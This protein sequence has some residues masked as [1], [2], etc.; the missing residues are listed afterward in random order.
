MGLR[1]KLGLLVV[2]YVASVM[3]LVGFL[4]IRAERQIFA[5]EMENR[6]ATLL[7]SLAIP[8]SVA[9]ADRDTPALDTYVEQFA[10]AAQ[11]VDLVYMAV[12]DHEGRVVAHTSSEEF[13]KMY[14][15]DFTLEAMS[16]RDTV[17]QIASHGG[18]ALLEL[19]V[20]VI[21]GLRW[22][23]LRAGFSL[24]RMESTFADRKFQLL[25]TAVL[26]AMGAAL[27][28]FA[29]LSVLVIRPVLKMSEMARQLR[30]GQRQARVS[31]PQRDEMGALGRQLNTMAEQLERYTESL[32]KAVQERTQDLAS[33]NSKLLAA[34]T[35]LQRLARTDS[36]TGLY[37][38][39]HFMEQLM[40]ETRRGK[41][42]PLQF[43]VML[44]DVDHFKQFNDAH[45]HIAGD[46]AL[47]SVGRVLELN[48]RVTDVVARYGGEE[49]VALLLDT[50]PAEGLATA[51]KLRDVVART[52]VV[53][54]SG[55]ATG[56]VTISIG[57]A[58]YPHDAVDEK[59]LIGCADRALYTSKNAGRNR[60]TP[61]TEQSTSAESRA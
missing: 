46:D 2:L 27:V 45:G 52:P 25:S 32:E 36:L 55:R 56:T 29:V 35:Q 9:I 3:A 43:A 8:C 13:G 31:I 22:G 1:L 50:A 60:V 20:P 59:A 19:A 26:V 44:I 30:Q 38:R 24:Q 10:E 34:N 47:K 54:E 39:R 48:L 14:Q 17:R 23:T 7:R 11:S 53:D 16:T 61:W 6:A 18:D 15:D 40:F 58:F 21:G 5:R 57:M 12:L 33:S 4:Q 42:V 49:F 51:E 41:R 28:A 37:N